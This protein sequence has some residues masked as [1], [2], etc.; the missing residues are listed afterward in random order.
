MASSYVIEQ[1][2]SKN[3]NRQIAFAGDGV[4][5][6]GQMDYPESPPDLSGSYP[7]IFTLHSAGCHTRKSMSHFA[8][9][10]VKSGY[11]IF[12][13]DKRGT[14]RSG[15]GGSGSSTQDAVLAYE[16]ALEQPIVDPNRVVILAQAEGSTLLG[17][18]YGLFAR[19]QKPMGVALIGNMLNEREILALDTRLQIINGANDW[20]SWKRYARDAAKAHKEA[21]PHHG[22]SYFVA[23]GANRELRTNDGLHYEAMSTLRDWLAAFGPV[24]S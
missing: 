10:A 4:R 24:Y 22:A 18:N 5:L 9:I 12:R 3:S 7:L 19:H 11:A 1:V 21:Y 17:N 15:A 20:L 6:A 8:S 14:G 16:T 2:Q 23:E 13:W